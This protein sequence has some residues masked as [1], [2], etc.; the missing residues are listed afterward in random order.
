MP[1]GG[2][3]IGV[4]SYEGVFGAVFL[5]AVVEGEEAGEVFCVGD[6]CCPHSFL[7]VIGFVHKENLHAYLSW[8]Q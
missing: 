5:E 7:S 1:F 6:E 4:Q 8:T 2:E 3:G